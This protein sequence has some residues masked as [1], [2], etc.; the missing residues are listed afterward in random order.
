MLHFGDTIVVSYLLLSKCRLHATNQ[1]KM[2]LNVVQRHTN[3]APFTNIN[4]LLFKLS[5]N[6]FPLSLRRHWSSHKHE[7]SIFK[8][9]AN[10]EIK[11]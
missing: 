8:V 4:F 9:K 11:E 10:E 5:V 7:Y 2:I 3:T 1:Q 6:F